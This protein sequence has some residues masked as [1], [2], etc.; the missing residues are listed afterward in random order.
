MSPTGTLHVARHQLTIKLDG[1]RVF[2]V[3]SRSRSSRDVEEDHVFRSS[4]HLGEIGVHVCD[5]S[6]SS[7][8]VSYREGS[9]MSGES[10]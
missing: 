1:N 7:D 10:E 8:R 4:E 2:I 9:R 3:I 6:T 5:N